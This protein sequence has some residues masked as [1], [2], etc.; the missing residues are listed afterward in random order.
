MQYD[1]WGEH[2]LQIINIG[3]RLKETSKI[4]KKNI[5]LSVVAL[6]LCFLLGYAA[7]QTA[8]LLR[9]W[10]ASEFNN[11]KSNRNPNCTETTEKPGVDFD[12]R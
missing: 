5:V 7:F 12:R 2:V 3:F 6:F 8:F 11:C 4:M 1:E 9:T 10:I